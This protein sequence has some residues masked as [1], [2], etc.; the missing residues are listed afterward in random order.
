MIEKS[1]IMQIIRDPECNLHKAMTIIS[2]CHGRIDNDS[3]NRKP[4]GPVVWRGWQIEA[5]KE[6]LA[7]YGVEA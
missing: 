5:A 1:E 3:Q 4:E 6:I 7:L 2:N